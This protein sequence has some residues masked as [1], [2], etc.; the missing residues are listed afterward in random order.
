MR[1]AFGQYN[2][3]I[4]YG[5]HFSTHMSL[6]L[7]FLGG[8][9]YTLGH[10]D[11]AIACMVAA[12]YPR[13]AQV[14]SDNKCYLQALRYL[15]VLAVEPRCLTARDVDTKEVVYMPI[16]IR[17]QEQNAATKEL[18]TVD[19]SLIAPTLIP[20]ID[21]VQW[22]KVESPRYWPILVHV[23][24]ETRHRQALIRSQTLFV[25]RRSAFLSYMEDPK[26]SRSL[27]VRSGGST[28]DA[29]TLDNPHLADLETQQTGDLAKFITS[30]SNETLFLGAADHLCRGEGATPDERTFAAYCHAALLDSLLQDKPRT[31]QTHLTLY[32]YR[33]MTPRSRYFH[34]RL[35]DLRFLSEFYGK[36]FDRR[37]SGRAENN[38]RPPLLRET[39]V[40]GAL[41]TLDGLLDAVRGAPEFSRAFAQYARGEPVQPT[42]EDVSRALGWYLLRNTI[43]VS[44]LL[45]VLKGLAEQ[46][47]RQC[48]GAAPPIGTNDAD[49]L[50]QGIKEVIHATGSQFTTAIGSGWSMRSLDEIVRAWSAGGGGT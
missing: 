36:T 8:G 21:N 16:R 9:R 26:G 42:S 7:L 18:R 17:V 49:K 3:P 46:A 10:S 50:D 22:V 1:T 23:A 35:H 47:H 31:L 12:F 14:S 6:G 27:L 34:L 30:F 5:T 39:A 24:G 44:T 4:R 20:N 32:K 28:A 48:I 41:L 37:F 11:A 45:A 38:P 15:W 33:T 13:F 25:K 29:A 43:P 19:K 2:M 40:G